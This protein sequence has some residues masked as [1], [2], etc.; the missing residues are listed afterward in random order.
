MEYNNRDLQQQAW[1]SVKALGRDEGKACVDTTR[2][3]L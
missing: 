2:F 3:W 1:G